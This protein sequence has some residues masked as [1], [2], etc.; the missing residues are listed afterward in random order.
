M[1]PERIVL[2]VASLLLAAGLVVWAAGGAVAVQGVGMWLW[3]G[4]VAVLSLP[5]LLWLLD[6]IVR[7]VRR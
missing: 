4:A 7:A 6:A 1:K 5:L 3:V 2:V